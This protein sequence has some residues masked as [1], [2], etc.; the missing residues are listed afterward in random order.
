MRNVQPLLRACGA[1]AVFGALA[2]LLATATPADAK[3]KVSL[4]STPK[5]APAPSAP[6]PHAPASA[7]G[8]RKGPGKVDVAEPSI[9]PDVH[10]TVRSRGFFDRLMDWLLWRRPAPAAPSIAQPP[11]AR[12]VAAVP[13]PATTPTPV[14]APVVPVVLPAPGPAAP[15]PA[16]TVQAEEKDKG[17]TGAPV[18]GWR[19][20]EW[21]ARGYVLHLKNG[22]AIP[23]GFYQDKGDQ[24]VIP[25]YGGSYGLSKSMIAR[26]VEVKDDGR[27]VLASPRR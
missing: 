24:V 9:V 7:P 25:Q 13:A 17:T 26:I 2:C 1:A 6:K 16:G 12:P 10:V 11:V 8:A 20:Q 27:E 3:F 18:P 14:P 15:V 23:V 22:S 4:R 19:R 21:S 5:S